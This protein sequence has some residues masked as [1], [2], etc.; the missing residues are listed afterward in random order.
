MVG[1]NNEH[2]SSE[3]VSRE[4][5]YDENVTGESSTPPDEHGVKTDD[6]VHRQERSPS[7]DEFVLRKNCSM[8]EERYVDTDEDPIVDTDDDDSSENNIELPDRNTRRPTEE[9]TDQTKPN[10]CDADVKEESDSTSDGNYLFKNIAENTDEPKVPENKTI[11]YEGSKFQGYTINDA[12]LD[13]VKITSANPER[14]ELCNEQQ[15]NN[16]FKTDGQSISLTTDVSRKMMIE[17]SIEPELN[18]F[19]NKMVERILLLCL[20]KDYVLSNAHHVSE[21][22]DDTKPTNDSC[23]SQINHNTN[24]KI[25]NDTENKNKQTE[26]DETLAAHIQNHIDEH[27][28]SG[29]IADT[30][31]TDRLLKCMKNMILSENHTESMMKAKLQEI[32]NTTMRH[33]H[34]EQ[35]DFINCDENQEKNTVF[36]TSTTNNAASL[37]E[38]LEDERENS[39]LDNTSNGRISKDVKTILE[40][41][42]VTLK[43]QNPP[44]PQML[45]RTETITTNDEDSE[46]IETEQNVPLSNA[47]ETVE[48]AENTIQQQATSNSSILNVSE[49]FTVET[50]TNDSNDSMTAAVERT[51]T[52]KKLLNVSRLATLKIPNPKE[53]DTSAT[54]TDDVGKPNTVD[55]KITSENPTSTNNGNIVINK[56]NTAEIETINETVE[57]SNDFEIKIWSPITPISND[58][59]TIVIEIPNTRELKTT[60]ETQISNELR[61]I[62]AEQ[63]N[64]KEIVN[65]RYYA[66]SV[67]TG[68]ETRFKLSSSIDATEIVI[69]KRRNSDEIKTPSNTLVSNRPVIITIEIETD[70]KSSNA[71]VIK[72]KSNITIPLVEVP[73]EIETVSEN[74]NDTTIEELKVTETD[75]ASKFALSNSTRISPIEEPKKIE[76]HIVSEP[77]ETINHTIVQVEEETIAVEI[78]SISTTNDTPPTTPVELQKGEIALE[79]LLDDTSS[80]IE[81]TVKNK[82]Q[83]IL[84]ADPKIKETINEEVPITN[85]PLLTAALKEPYDSENKTIEIDATSKNLVLNSEVPLKETTETNVESADAPTISNCTTALVVEDTKKIETEKMSSNQVIDSTP[86]IRT[87]I[88][89]GVEIDTLKNPEPKNIAVDELVE[90]KEIESASVT[91]MSNDTPKDIGNKIDIKIGPDS[92]S[93][94]NDTDTVTFEKLNSVETELVTSS[95]L[96]SD[97]Q[98]IKNPEKIK[99]ETTPELPVLN[100]KLAVSVEEAIEIEM[101]SVDAPTI[102]DYTTAIHGD[103]DPKKL[104]SEK[105]ST[106]LVLNNTLDE[107]IKGL[108]KKIETLQNDLN[109]VGFE[110]PSIPK[111]E[112]TTDNLISNGTQ[113]LILDKLQEIKIEA[114]SEPPV[115]NDNSDI[116]VDGTIKL[117]IESVDGSIISKYYSPTII[118]EDP[119]PPKSEQI[120]TNSIMSSQSEPI[121]S[122]INTLSQNITSDNIDIESIESDEKIEI[123]TISETTILSNDTPDVVVDETIKMKVEAVS[124]TTIS[125]DTTSENPI[126]IHTQTILVEQ[127]AIEIDA[128][129]V[130]I[131][132][133][134]SEEQTN[135]EINT[136]INDVIIEVPN[137]VET[138][139]TT[140]N[141]TSDGAKSIAVKEPEEVA[142]ET[143][144]EP[145]LINYNSGVL[146]EVPNEIET[147]S[148]NSNDTTI[149]ELKVTETDTASKSALS[150]STRISPI[151]EPKKIEMHIVSEPLET[152]NHTIVQVEEE[153]IAVEIKSISTTAISNDTPPTTTVE[154]QKVEIALENLLDDTSSVIENTVTNKTREILE[155]D[156]KIIETINDEVPITNYPLS[157]TVKDLKD[158]GEN[159]ID[160]QMCPFVKISNFTCTVTTE[161]EDKIEIETDSETFLNDTDIVTVEKS[162]TA[163]TE[164]TTNDLIFIMAQSK[165]VDEIDKVELEIMPT[166]L[167]SNNNSTVQVEETLENEKETV[168]LNYT[169]DKNPQEI[170]ISEETLT[171]SILN[172][173]SNVST[174]LLEKID[175]TPE[176]TSILNNNPPISVEDINE[177]DSIKTTT[178]TL[179]ANDNSTKA[180]I[181]LNIGEAE[182]TSKPPVPNDTIAELVKTPH[183]IHINTSSQVQVSNTPDVTIEEVIEIKNDYLSTAPITNNVQTEQKEEPKKIKTKIVPEILLNDTNTAIIEEPNTVKIGFFTEMPISSGAQSVSN[184]ETNEV[185]IETTNNS[186]VSNDNHALRAEKSIKLEKETVSATISSNDI[187]DTLV[188]D[189][190][191]LET[192]ETSKTP[193]QNNTPAVQNNV[194]KKIEIDSTPEN[195]ILNDCPSELLKET[196][197]LE[198]ETVSMAKLSNCSTEQ[199]EIENVSEIIVSNDRSP[200]QAEKPIAMENKTVLGHPIS[201]DDSTI[202]VQ[203]LVAMEIDTYKCSNH[204]QNVQIEESKK[205]EIDIT[206]ELPVLI[207]NTTEPI[208]EDTITE[209]IKSESSTII[210]NDEVI[211]V[212]DVQNIKVE[213]VPETLLNDT[214]IFIKS[215]AANSIQEISGKELNK[216]ETLIETP[217]T[218]DSLGLTMIEPN[219]VEIS[220]T[221]NLVLKYYTTE[222]VE[223]AKQVDTESVSLTAISND[224]LKIQA[225][226]ENEIDI[227]TDCETLLNESDTV[228]SEEPK[229]VET[230]STTDNLIIGTQSSTVEQTEGIEI[231]DISKSNNNCPVSTENIDEMNVENITET[232][233]PNNTSA[234]T[235]ITVNIGEIDTMTNISVLNDDT[236]TELGESTEVRINNTLSQ[237]LI[238]NDTPPNASMDETMKTENKTVFATMITNETLTMQLDESK[239]IKLDL[240]LLS[241]PVEELK[242]IE[243]KTVLTSSNSNNT[244]DVLV[245][246]EPNEAETDLTLETFLSNDSLVEPIDKSKKIDT[247]TVPVTLLTDNYNDSLEESNLAETDIILTAI[248]ISS[249]PPNVFAE[250]SNK[251]EIETTCSTSNDTPTTPIEKCNVVEIETLTQKPN[252]TEIRFEEEI[253]TSLDT[254][255]L[256]FTVTE[257]VVEPKPVDV[258]SMFEQLI[259]DNTETVVEETE[260]VSKI[261][262]SN[263]SDTDVVNIPKVVDMNN[264]TC[265]APTIIK[266]EWVTNESISVE[267]ESLDDTQRLNCTSTVPTDDILEVTVPTSEDTNCNLA[268]TALVETQV[269]REILTSSKP[270]DEPNDVEP[271]RTNNLPV[272]DKSQIVVEDGP[273]NVHGTQPI[274]DDNESENNNLLTENVHVEIADNTPQNTENVHEQ[275]D[276]ACETANDTA[277]VTVEESIA[278]IVNNTFETIDQSCDNNNTVK[279]ISNEIP[280]VCDENMNVRTNDDKVGT[281]ESAA[282]DNSSEHGETSKHSTADENRLQEESYGIRKLEM[283]VQRVKASDDDYFE[284]TFVQLER[285]EKIAARKD[286]VGDENET[287]VDDKS[288]T[289]NECDLNAVLCASSLQ[290]ALTVLDSKIRF[291]FKNKTRNSS[292]VNP[293]I[294]KSSRETSTSSSDERNSNFTE[295]QEFFKKIERKSQK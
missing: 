208:D 78:K 70:T 105:T 16:I 68:G 30:K 99:I 107:P 27:D 283:S 281:E 58:T 161:V 7:A 158:S 115:F 178:E 18:S 268:E 85:Y 89:K 287:G 146:V 246:E 295:A 51:P 199:K 273:D 164:L 66:K 184:E 125:N 48:N 176:E 43:L 289:V 104:K 183:E 197:K 168:S 142:K 275:N 19:K 9:N 8:N 90:G 13:S 157:L 213:T 232:S 22:D 36:Q 247:E 45:G 148:E 239:S 274:A 193:V 145:T 5:L 252:D 81:N 47:I 205:V 135:T 170:L 31:K 17:K 62:A 42:P 177:I 117:E 32:V 237:T 97:Q 28:L 207:N 95:M 55:T 241:G 285:T 113:V 84:K 92:T 220:K 228:I 14:K 225:E 153:T 258:E 15:I 23:E 292:S 182:T 169:T 160:L 212:K 250:N 79:N 265:E 127:V 56:S 162:I 86:D 186:S 172:S 60:T 131:I 82:T 65:K 10:Q 54:E 270:V 211:P 101:E 256:N 249:D 106:T 180:L 128:K 219:E 264:A 266:S 251:V 222:L 242:T 139:L 243:T 124:A 163:K 278:K 259:I 147:V 240:E 236:Q 215:T 94:L 216:I 218:N 210:S 111:I 26:I 114:T 254:T 165:K 179:L 132:N 140:E 191:E 93:L 195:P 174:D 277:N 130:L 83:E 112:L 25:F 226:V 229:T 91:V 201:D 39:K 12:V 71:E 202:V 260:L 75:T 20:N 4:T 267:T 188:E 203:K 98:T 291:K 159:Q 272:I 173:I 141:S 288:Y 233:L 189:P 231:E 209:K 144:T 118:V 227:E 126:T 120:L 235:L 171:T 261:P 155:A 46:N 167:I 154:L 282:P 11:P 121:E 151:E 269:A 136:S 238:S 244:P 223:E 38:A 234:E 134:N 133:D 276:M 280:N 87:D 73:N 57:H 2:D 245:E 123:E 257:C 109:I 150:N 190:V 80:V 119:K 185:E 88:P 262:L 53:I 284:K 37:E 44:G 49:T 21:S 217:I 100:E 279:T 206:S 196:N 293:T 230:E 76:M 29:T 96:S 116:P 204:N 59:K 138:E 214:N 122:G 149:V 253:Q 64:I 248:P 40:E 72:N 156:P 33:L 50:V 198:I 77:L 34:D 152:I 67:T 286:V 263:K 294:Y 61:N 1:Q 74:S 224:T 255:L 192:Q 137:T 166:S 52:L 35:K 181:K 143:V 41:T 3:H 110:E 129:Q 221:E 103:K 271:N 290:E 200:V 175:T 102:S 24:N 63:K 108:P 69:I 187:P 6:A 194:Q